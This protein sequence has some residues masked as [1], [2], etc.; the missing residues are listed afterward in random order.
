MANHVYFTITVDGLDD[1]CK[2]WDKAFPHDTHQ[3]KSFWNDEWV[4][5]KEL[6]DLDK[7]PMFAHMNLEYDEDGWLKDSYN[8]YCNNIGAKW[9]NVDEVGDN[10]IYGYSAWS[11]PVPFAERIV[12]YLA[13]VTGKD[14]S[15]KMTYEDEFRNFIGIDHFV[16]YEEDGEYFAEHSE[17]YVDS[18][19]FIAKIK[20][21]FPNLDD[22]DFDWD[23]PN[24]DFE[25]YTAQ[26]Y[27][28]NL[29]HDFWER[30]YWE[31][32]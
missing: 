11:H 3:R 5:V 14:I 17:E 20:E 6:V 28:D 27:A 21:K 2:A 24:E 18:D 23:E 1:G 30:E 26:E 22:E 29:V 31:Y 15:A 9:C 32:D 25:G 8:W 19:D 10:Y 13:E 4:E 12:A 7:L 16:S